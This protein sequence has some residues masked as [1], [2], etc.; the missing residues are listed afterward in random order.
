MEDHKEPDILSV[1]TTV[2]ALAD[3]Q[4]LARDL[5][6]RRLAACVQVEPGLT[7]HYR[8]QGQLC[9][10]AE[11]RLTVKTLPAARAALEAFFRERHPYDV[12]QFL[13][14]TQHASAAYAAWVAEQVT[15]PGAP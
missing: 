11:V 9:E 1:T 10:E 8:W 14:S 5:V 7:S 4:A 13:W 3:A 2:G 6:E 12:P 15:L